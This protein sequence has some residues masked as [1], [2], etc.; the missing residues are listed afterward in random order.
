METVLGDVPKAERCRCR[1]GVKPA[2]KAPTNAKATAATG[3]T[4]DASTVGRF[5]RWLQQ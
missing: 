2:A 3:A 4:D 5:K 1:E